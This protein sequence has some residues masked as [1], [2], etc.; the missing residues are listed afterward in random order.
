MSTPTPFLAYDALVGVIT[1]IGI[2]YLFYMH[3]YVVEVHQFLYFLL[4]GF[5]VFSL[6]GPLV[7]LLVP[8]WAHAVHGLS[9][10]FV[11]FALYDPVHNDLRK[12][13]WAG[14]V[15][16]NPKWVRQTAEWMTPM[17]DDILEA[18]S[19]T[20]MILTPT[21]VAANLDYSRS[22]VNR[23]LTKLADHGYIEKMERG[24][25]RI[26]DVGSEYLEGS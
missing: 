23:H 18:F 15:F 1:A 17:D 9:A 5:L 22:E 12:D 2:L 19:S 24:K 25:Y 6:G 10:T 4:A 21:V 16:Q 11:V 3:R 8:E 14:L 20:D 26:T 13:E 7:N